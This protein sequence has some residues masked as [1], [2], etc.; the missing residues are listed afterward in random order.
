MQL[1]IFEILTHSIKINILIFHDDRNMTIV[2]ETLIDA[3]TTRMLEL[4]AR[5]IVYIKWL[6]KIVFDE[7][8]QISVMLKLILIKTINAVIQR[9][10]V[11]DKETHT[12]KRFFHNSKIKQCYNCWQYDHI[13]NEYFSLSKCDWCEKSEH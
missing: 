1:N 7:E 3:N 6:K 12:C 2:I 11:W 4:I 8:E 13:E 10:L 9:Y 5:K